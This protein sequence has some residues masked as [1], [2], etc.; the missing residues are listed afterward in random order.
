MTS[1]S[2]GHLIMAVKRGFSEVP[3]IRAARGQGIRQDFNP[4]RKVIMASL[5]KRGS[6]YYL[7][8]Y[9]GGK[10]SKPTL[11]VVDVTFARAPIGQYRLALGMFADRNQ[12]APAYLFA[13]DGSTAD[14]WLILDS[15]WLTN[16]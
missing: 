10:E 1:L 11:D 9:V 3:F 4:N 6:V 15:V 7:S 14:R 13:S 5:R 12:A 8:Y 2:V 16:P